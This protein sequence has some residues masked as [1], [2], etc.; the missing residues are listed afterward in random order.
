VELL[1]AILVA[2]GFWALAEFLLMTQRPQYGRVWFFV[3]LVL[4]FLLFFALVLNPGVDPEPYALAI[5][6]IGALAL[7]VATK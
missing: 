6:V 2:L 7:T 4:L 3:F 5:A 1:I